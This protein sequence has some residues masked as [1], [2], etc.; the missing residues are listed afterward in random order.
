MGNGERRG[1]LLGDGAGV[2]KGRTIAGII[3]ENIQNGRT[4]AIWLS[5]SSDLVVDTRRDMTDVGISSSYTLLNIKDLA[6]KPIKDQR[7]VL[8]GTY[9]SLVSKKRKPAYGEYSTRL[10]QIIGWCGPNFDGMN[11]NF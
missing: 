6:Y 9:R 10:D 4:K 5:V 3:Y 2:G 11:I 7:A 1:F 8:F